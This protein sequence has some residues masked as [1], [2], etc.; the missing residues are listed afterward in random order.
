MFRGEKFILDVDDDDVQ[1]SQPQPAAPSPFTFVGDIQERKPRAAAPPSAPTP[2]HS[3]GFP[4]HKKRP[5][6]SRFKQRKQQSE[7]TV[8]SD[9]TTVT[10]GASQPATSASQQDDTTPKSWQDQEKVQI[11]QQNR[12][13]LSGMSEAEIEEARAELLG[14]LD[15]DL[16]Q[17]LLR[18][19][20]IDSGSNEAESLQ[21]PPEPIE[22]GIL[23]REKPTKQKSVAFADDHSSA[24]PKAPKPTVQDLK[25]RKHSNKKK[26]KKSPLTTQSTSRSPR[27]PP[28][29]DPDSTTFLNDLHEKYFPSLPSDPSKLEWMRVRK[30][31]KAAYSPASTSVNPNEIRFSFTGELLAPKTAA[32]IPVT[33]GLHHHGDAPEAAGYTI[34]ELAHLS[35]STYAAQRCIAFQTLGRVL[36]RLGKGEFGD[37]GED[38]ANRPGADETFGELAR[39]L[40][41]EV[42]KEHVIAQLIAESE[43]NGVD[44]G[45]H[46]SAKAYA[47]EAVW[48]WRK[49]GGRRWKAD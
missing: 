10:S 11:D 3:T 29:L 13:M 16:I 26:M 24:P 46:M 6:Q 43:G 31:D 49:G 25:K 9:G 19:S 20:H 2:K 37:A 39:G 30:T 33:E 38:G 48:L 8:L 4:E 17:K 28:S 44:G 41:R 45:R 22:G 36:Y 7:K 42:E 18:R 27:N 32:S 23:H 15:P 5:V 47:T 21:P 35:R 12:D 34:P 14:S 1:Q 40:W